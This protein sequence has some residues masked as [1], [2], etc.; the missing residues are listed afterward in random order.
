MTEKLRR[1]GLRIGRH[2]GVD[3]FTTATVAQVMTG[4]VT[5]SDATSAIGDARALFL[6]GGHAAYPIVDGHR[7]VGIV[8][9]G[10]VLRDGWVDSQPCWSQP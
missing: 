1:R 6:K 10:D 8:S 7:L 5:T 3:P 9:R 2:Y 4:A